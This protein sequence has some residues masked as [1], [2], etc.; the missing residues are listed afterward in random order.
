MLACS[1][2]NSIQGSG[3]TRIDFFPPSPLSAIMTPSVLPF[4]ILQQAAGDQVSEINGWQCPTPLGKETD[5]KYY[6]Y[7]S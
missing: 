1:E 2:R 4:A 7:E 5:N 6:R 3:I